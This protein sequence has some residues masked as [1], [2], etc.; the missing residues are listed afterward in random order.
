MH[1]RKQFSEVFSIFPPKQPTLFYFEYASN[2]WISVSIIE[3]IFYSSD[4]LMPPKVYRISKPGF[5]CISQFICCDFPIEKTVSKKLVTILDLSPIPT[6]EYLESL[7]FMD[8]KIPFFTFP[9][10][11]MH[12]IFF[13][14]LGWYSIT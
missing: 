11:L 4:F 12:Q 9:G 6:I 7:I 8:W 10:N 13:Y 2:E 14:G 1:R 5:S 3:F